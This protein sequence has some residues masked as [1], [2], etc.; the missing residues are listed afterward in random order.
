MLRAAPS[1]L[2]SGRR[3]LPLLPHAL[4]RHAAGLR[5]GQHAAHERRAAAG[6]AA[7]E[8]LNRPV[9]TAVV[10]P[11]RGCWQETT[12]PTLGTTDGFDPTSGRR[13]ARSPCAGRVA[14]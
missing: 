5:A 12:R 13:E 3:E 11:K 1:V 4:A 8:G 14:G 10:A 9:A 7:G 2:G 6:A